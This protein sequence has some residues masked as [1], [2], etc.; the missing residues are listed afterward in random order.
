MVFRDYM[1]RCKRCNIPYKP[2][3]VSRIRTCV[4]C[5]RSLLTSRSDRLNCLI[6]NIK[7]YSETQNC[8]PS[9]EIL[10]TWIKYK[11]EVE[12]STINSYIKELEDSKMIT[13]IDDECI[14]RVKLIQ[15]YP[16]TS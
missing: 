5:R 15:S 16:T 4:F 13:F 7:R 9:K 1:V 14:K 8:L 3:N 12:D 2:D 10:K 6:S 11:F